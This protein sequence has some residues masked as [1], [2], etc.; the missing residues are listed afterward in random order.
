MSYVRVGQE[1]N[2]KNV[3]GNN[4][5]HGDVLVNTSIPPYTKGEPLDPHRRN[6]HNHRF[7]CSLFSEHVALKWQ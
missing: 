4:F 3:V 5:F 2:S 6:H 1:E 7:W